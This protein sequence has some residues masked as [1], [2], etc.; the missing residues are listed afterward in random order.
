MLEN[1]QDTAIVFSMRGT[2]EKT[3]GTSEESKVRRIS[4]E[5]KGDPEGWES[6]LESTSGR[7]GRAKDG[8]WPLLWQEGA[9]QHE[10]GDRAN[11]SGDIV[12]MIEAPS[13]SI[14]DE[15]SPILTHSFEAGLG[16][17]VGDES[18]EKK[19]MFLF[20]QRLYLK[21]I[22]D[23]WFL[24]YKYLILFFYRFYFLMYAYVCQCEYMPS[25]CRCL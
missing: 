15:C 2:Q 21:P 13:P 22:F 18:A 12:R 6:G 9:W 23:C 17:G 7:P 8:T 11:G 19:N 25:V 10:G 14:A 20:Q 1:T 24:H 3:L 5:R 16:T 4:W